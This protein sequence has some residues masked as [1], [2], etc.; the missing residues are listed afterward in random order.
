[1][2]TTKTRTPA[3]ALT[4]AREAQAS[5]D[6][7]EARATAEDDTAARV[8]AESVDALVND[9]AAA[10]D[11]G[12]RIDNHRRL[13]RA[14][15]TKAAQHT[16]RR[17]QIARDALA[18]EAARLD[19]AADTAAREAAAHQARVDELL[20]QLEDLDGVS[21]QVAPVRTSGGSEF[22]PTGKAEELAA[23]VV[24]DRFRASVIR[25]V[26]EHGQVP[27]Y[28]SA[29]DYAE[30]AGGLTTVTMNHAMIAQRR[31]WFT[32][33]MLAAYLAGTILEFTPEA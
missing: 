25:Y 22:Y 27:E 24:R 7:L 1:M 12:R 18:L 17:D 16:Q 32:A 21:Y 10:D 33:P 14:Y 5:A 4:D 26:L 2:P 13:A 6:E 11:I 28:A 15:R 19:Q 23:N 31:E 3:D 30:P 8:E 9:P 29:L 20:A